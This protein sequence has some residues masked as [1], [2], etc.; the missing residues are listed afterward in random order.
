MIVVAGDGPHRQA[1]QAR[2]PRALLLEVAEAHEEGERRAAPAGRDRHGPRRPRQDV[3]AR[4]ASARR[5][6]RCGEAGGI[7]QHIGA[8]HVETDARRDHLPR[9]AGPRGLHGHARARQPGHRH[10]DPGGRGRRRRDAADD[11]GDRPRQGGQGADGRGGEQDRQARGQSRSASSRSCSRTRSSPRSSAARR[12]FVEVSAKT[13]EGIDK[14]LESIQLQAEV[15]EL[16]APVNAPAQGRRDRIA[17]RQGPRPGGDGAGQ[18]GHAQEGRHR[19]RRRGVRA[20]AR[21]E[22]RKRQGGRRRRAPPS[23]WRSRACRTC[24]APATT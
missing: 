2:R 9:Y 20:R 3:A 17:P 14:L 19:P 8:Y 7:T 23:R 10:R 11:R 16:K 6:W 1:R 4:R 13:G 21:D 24:R 15:L 5:A 18:V 12:Q 22:R